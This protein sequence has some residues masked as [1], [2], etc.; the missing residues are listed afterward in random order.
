L[1]IILFLLCFPLL[2]AAQ[3]G[4][5]T[6]TDGSGAPIIKDFTILEVDSNDKGVL[7][8]RMT[9]MQ[10][11]AI[12]TAATAAGETV[13]P[14]LTLYCTDCCYNGGGTPTGSMYYY[15]GVEWKPLDSGCSDVNGI[16]PCE[17]ATITN[18][19]IGGHFDDVVATPFLFDDLLTSG[20]QTGI[21]LAD[22]RLHH[23]NK[24]IIEFDLNRTLPAGYKIV[25][26]WSDTQWNNNL[27]LI[28]EFD[29]GGST[30][31]PT[32]DTLDGP[33]TNSANV[34]TGARNQTL[35]IDIVANLDTITVRS[36]ADGDGTDPY[37]LEIKILT[38]GG[39][40]IEFYTCS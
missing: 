23:D 33:L 2:G 14:G 34:H 27:G 36:S 8:P 10:R 24:D 16:P 12:N 13:T 18:L 1:Y 40:E 20:T 38:D 7:L 5:N 39:D 30:S 32:I 15:N 9:I 37:F 35:T 17:P 26:Y 31:Q 3:V 21:D 11:D 22:L 25:I 19:G 28:V 4:I 6:P 29:A